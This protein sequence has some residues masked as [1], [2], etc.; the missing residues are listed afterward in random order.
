[1]FGGGLR[2]EGQDASPYLQW[3]IETA[4][5]L[6]KAGKVTSLLMTGDGS[7]TTHDEP[8]IMRKIAIELGVPEADIAVDKFG[9]DTYDSCFRAHAIHSISSATVISQGYHI[10]RA[11]LTCQKVGIDTI[12]VNAQTK[13]G[14]S[15]GYYDIVR[16]WLS[17]DKL[18]IQLLDRKYR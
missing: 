10:P 7:Y 4:V 3:R 12:G 13:S 8:N 11:I 2:N 6:Y 9:F 18:F 5:E 15:W 1:V 14:K 17:T 16:E